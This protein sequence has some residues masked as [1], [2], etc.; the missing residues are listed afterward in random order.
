VDGRD[1]EQRL[2]CV[3]H[4]WSG[5]QPITVSYAWLRDGQPIGGATARDY[6]TGPPDVGRVVRCRAT[7]TNAVGTTVEDALPGTGHHVPDVL[8][9]ELPPSITGTPKVGR[10]L[11]CEPGRWRAGTAPQF[12]FRWLTGADEQVAT[13]RKWVPEGSSA[14]Q[15]V[16][17]EVTAR[18]GAGMQMA[19]SDYVGIMP[20][21]PPEGSTTITGGFAAG[22]TLTCDPGNW[23]PAA[24]NGF[25]YR[26]FRDG[27]EI[28]GATDQRL[29]TTAADAGHEFACEATGSNEDGST[30]RRSGDWRLWPAADQGPSGAPWSSPT[31]G[32]TPV[33]VPP[34]PAPTAPAAGAASPPGRAPGLT[35]ATALRSMTVSS[36]SGSATLTFD[37]DRTGRLEITGT[38]HVPGRRGLRVVQVARA[39]RR[40]GV[41]RVTVRPGP[42]A[43]R[44]ALGRRGRLKVRLRITYRPKDARPSTIVRTLTLRKRR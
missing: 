38:A 32:P 30:S 23:V 2:R 22:G 40:P 44:R 9:N 8:S 3:D 18:N 43:A 27:A 20:L 29:A 42:A 7:A 13:G 36:R 15:H 5:A 26:W 12:T 33:P 16:R 11:T 41:Q 28:P 24:T 1:Y 10:E 34:P 19:W 14:R 35:A 31:A 4:A 37:F 6:T 17:C 25:T 39:V 21:E